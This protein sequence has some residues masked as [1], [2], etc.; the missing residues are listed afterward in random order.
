MQRLLAATDLSPRGTAA[1]ARAGRLAR[2]FRAPMTLFHVVDHELPDALRRS[3]Q[4]Q[5]TALLRAE[6][7]R[8]SPALGVAVDV[9]VVAG[10]DHHAIAR[11]AEEIAADLIVVGASPPVPELGGRLGITTERL[12]REVAIPVLAVRRAETEPYAAVLVAVELVEASRRV[13]GLA[14]RVAAVEP[15]HVL[16]VPSD[17]AGRDSTDAARTHVDPAVIAALDD[18]VARSGF[19]PG[20]AKSI[21]RM[22]TIDNLLPRVV[23]DV[24]AD[25]VVMGTT[26]HNR[27]ALGRWLTG[28]HAEKALASVETDLL[29]VPLD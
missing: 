15:V 22:G 26:T 6:A 1:V 13:L 9:R 3:H 24:G 10:R 16:N 21:V 8:L 29:A 2:Q 5:A 12:M 18:L 4:L 14:H 23:A 19:E 20:A 17:P 28:S 11:A 27:T 25:L 7:E